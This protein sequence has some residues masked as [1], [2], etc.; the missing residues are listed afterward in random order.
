[1]RRDSAAGVGVWPCRAAKS[2]A[3]IATGTSVVRVNGEDDSVRSSPL[4]LSPAV[5]GMGPLG[6]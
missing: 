2:R 1:M 3:L 6:H 4:V 5:L